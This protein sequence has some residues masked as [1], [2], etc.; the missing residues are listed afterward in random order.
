M[1]NALYVKNIER[2][3]SDL[4]TRAE[5]D[6]ILKEILSPV[7]PQEGKLKKRLPELKRATLPPGP[8]SRS[9]LESVQLKHSTADSQHSLAV[10]SESPLAHYVLG[11]AVVSALVS[12]ACYNHRRGSFRDRCSLDDINVERDNPASH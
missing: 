2:A 12:T 10:H 7:F 1:Q 6:R 9:P 11:L 5:R 3:A 4:A 8:A